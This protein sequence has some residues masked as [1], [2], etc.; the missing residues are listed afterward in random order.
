MMNIWFV[1]ISVHRLLRYRIRD[2]VTTTRGLRDREELPD[3]S[4]PPRRL[5]RA[6]TTTAKQV[7]NNFSTPHLHTHLHT[8]TTPQQQQSAPKGSCGP[9]IDISFTSTR[10]ISKLLIKWLIF[11]WVVNAMGGASLAGLTKTRDLLHL[12]RCH[13]SSVAIEMR[14]VPL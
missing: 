12:P 13:V 14:E 8:T 1:L 3:R 2:R 9:A 11:N 10:I 7:R 4:V 5:S 6:S